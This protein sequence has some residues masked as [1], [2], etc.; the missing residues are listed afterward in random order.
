MHYRFT[1]K[2][3]PGAYQD[4]E[5]GPEDEFMRLVIF[6][7]LER[8]IQTLWQPQTH[9]HIFKDWTF[10]MHPDVNDRNLTVVYQCPGKDT[11]EQ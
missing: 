11:V 5:L 10:A 6:E 3:I 9:I 4:I 2:D 1:C 7:T 8:E